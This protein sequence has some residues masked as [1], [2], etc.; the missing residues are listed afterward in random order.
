[1]NI[2]RLFCSFLL[3]EEDIRSLMTTKTSKIEAKTWRNTLKYIAN[4]VSYMMKTSSHFINIYAYF[5]KD[6]L[7]DMNKRSLIKNYG[8]RFSEEIF[9]RH[10]KLISLIKN[11]ENS[12]KIGLPDLA[13]FVKEVSEIGKSELNE[14]GVFLDKLKNT[15]QGV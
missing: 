5:I 13:L 10:R 11:F 7:D 2:A 3:P 8:V 12:D 15:V 1:M 9:K 14:Q 4:L 6:F